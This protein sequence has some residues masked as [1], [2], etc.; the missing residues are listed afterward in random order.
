MSLM[1]EPNLLSLLTLGWE[2]VSMVVVGTTWMA[3]AKGTAGEENS[4]DD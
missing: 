3:L 4:K 1:A 2:L